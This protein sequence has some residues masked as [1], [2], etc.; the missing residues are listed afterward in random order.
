MYYFEVCGLVIFFFLL[1]FVTDFE[2]PFADSGSEYLPSESSGSESEDPQL[3]DKE[4]EKE[5]P[6]KSSRKKG[7]MKRSGRGISEKEN[8][9]LVKNTKTLREIQ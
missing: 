4:E 8:G 9:Q 7:K 2:D 5:T 1:W 3:S 6:V